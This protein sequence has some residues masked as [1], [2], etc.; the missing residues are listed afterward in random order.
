MD[1]LAAFGASASASASAARGGPFADAVRGDAALAAAAEL[2]AP[3]GV[4]AVADWLVA[5]A[6]ADGGLAAGG[7]PPPAPGLVHRDAVAAL[8]ALLTP[9]DAD[10]GGSGTV[11][12]DSGAPLPP[13]P[14]FRALFD[15]LQAA[16]EDAAL[17]DPADPALDDWLPVP[18]LRAFAR[19][20]VEGVADVLGRVCGG[21]PF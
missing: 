17:L 13:P 18:T 2:A 7:A 19:G 10:D 3:G 6:V 4:D 5:L 20:A 15:A 16:A 9:A 12:R 11:Y 21:V 8:A 14:G 1:E